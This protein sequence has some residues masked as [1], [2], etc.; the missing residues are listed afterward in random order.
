MKAR[1]TLVWRHIW[2]HNGRESHVDG[3]KADI[4][5]NG[6][7]F[8]NGPATSIAAATLPPSECVGDTPTVYLVPYYVPNRCG[9]LWPPGYAMLILVQTLCAMRSGLRTNTLYWALLILCT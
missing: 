8:E 7:I 2:R 9:L 5:E 1:L 3:T 4:F 6:F